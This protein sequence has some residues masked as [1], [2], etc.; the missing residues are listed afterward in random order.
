M[1]KATYHGFIQQAQVCYSV[2]M[3]APDGG[4]VQ[5]VS[6]TFLLKTAACSGQ[7]RHYDSNENETRVAG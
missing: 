3:G 1:I 7:K 2:W 5:W 4:S 6:R